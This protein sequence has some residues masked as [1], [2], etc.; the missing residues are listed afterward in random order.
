MDKRVVVTGIGITSP[1]GNTI[2]D[3]WDSW[4]NGISNTAGL[5]DFGFAAA[6]VND[7]YLDYSG[8][9]LPE[10][11]VS[12]A[13]HFALS[14][15]VEA[16]ETAEISV[17]SI[18]PY[19]TGVILGC[20]L[21]VSNDSFL[22]SMLIDNSLLNSETISEDYAQAV[23][24]G[25]INTDLLEYFSCGY[26]PSS[27][28]SSALGIR[29]LSRSVSNS[30]ASGAYSV[31][32]GYERIKNG[33]LDMAITGG[34][35]AMINTNGLSL[36]TVLDV[37]SKEKDYT[38][39]CRPFDKNRSGFVLGEGAGLLILESLDKA[40]SRNAPIYAEI[41]GYSAMTDTYHMTTP[42]ITGN[43]CG[44]MMMSAAGAA[45]VDPCDI[46][47][48]SAQGASTYYSDLTETNGIKKAFGKRAYDVPVSSL[49]SMI[50]HLISAAGAV[51]LI[52]TILTM[53]HSII[54]PTINYETFD[55]ECDLDY[56]ANKSRNTKVRRAM[57]NSFGFGGQNVCVVLG[58]AD[59]L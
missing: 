45:G 34:A 36:F 55:P 46:D 47:Y 51:E 7:P 19:N 18:D 52:A 17:D 37:M 11:P 58:G 20:G 42:D 53:K 3:A 15:L 10:N 6:Q 59:T 27:L 23:K 28:I 49:K 30:C 38:R 13:S 26:H 16:L 21:S 50:G 31:C 40:K 44:E 2:S 29:K 1:A 14:A 56:V 54:L 25:Q 4:V 9:T 12:R 32:M 41:I 5:P 57:K 24:H 8:F 35:D 22:S 48:I 33:Q 39:A 43:L